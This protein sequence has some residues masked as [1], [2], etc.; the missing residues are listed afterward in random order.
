MATKIILIR[1]GETIWNKQ[2]KC[3]GFSDIPLN[4]TGKEQAML[5]GQA[6]KSVSFSAVYS[7]DLARAK[8]TGDEIAGQ[9]NMKVMTDARFREL[10]QGDL[11]GQSL[12]DLLA[13]HPGILKKWLENPADVQ[14]PGGESMRSLQKRAVVAL[15][16]I[17]DNH[18]DEIVAVVAHNLCIL[19]IICH[20]IKLDLNNFRRLKMDNASISVLEHSGSG[21]SLITINDTHHLGNKRFK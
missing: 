12:S 6:L 18:P 4:E 14:M 9:H 15:Q 13:D 2:K 20:S 1:H 11:E 5:L 3:Q 10:N 8:S 19:S 7:S 16:D 17:I 21:L